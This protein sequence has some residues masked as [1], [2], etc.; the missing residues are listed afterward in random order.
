LA[1]VGILNTSLEGIFVWVVG[2]HGCDGAFCVALV[3]RFLVMSGLQL[4]L[5][6]CWPPN[7]G[8]CNKSG[9]LLIAVVTD[10]R[11][12]APPGFAVVMVVVVVPKPTVRQDADDVFE[13]TVVAGGSRG[14]CIRFSFDLSAKLLMVNKW[15]KQRLKNY[16]DWNIRKKLKQTRSKII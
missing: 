2:S 6:S 4:R 7:F 5:D 12:C 8:G 9:V 14:L 3:G 10:R 15:G 13:E 16:V 1:T 11:C